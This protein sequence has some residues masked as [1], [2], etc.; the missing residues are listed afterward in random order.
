MRRFLSRALALILCLSLCL[1]PAVQALTADQLKELLREHYLNDIP[2]AALDAQTVEEVIEALNDPYTVYMDA[3]EYQAM[4]DSMSDQQVVGIGISATATEEGLLIMGTYDGSPAQK[5]GLVAGDLI[6]QVAGHNTAGETAATIT[7]WLQGEEGSKVDILVRHADG[8]EQSYTIPRAPV[9]I[10]ATVTE[11]LEDSSTGYINCTTFG[12]E[13]LGHFTEGTQA[14]DDVNL[15]IVDLRQN[16]G[17][18]VYAVTQTLGT[19]LGEGTMFY[20]RDG[21]GKYYYYAS[22][23]EST[24]IY[25]AIVLTSPMTASAAEIFA[26]A[27]KDQAGGLVIGAHTF[28]KGVAQL[29]LS[30]AQ[31]P[32]TF[33]QGDALK[34]T[35]YQYYGSEGNTAQNI[36]VVPDLLVA[37]EDADEIAQL[38]SSQS[39]AGDTNGWLRLHLGGWRWYVEIAK[40]MTADNAPYF[41]ELLSALPPSAELYLGNGADWTRTT[42]AQVAANTGVAGYAP[43][44]FADVAG[45]DCE[46]AANTLHTYAMLNGYADGSFRPDGTITRAEFCAL[47]CQAMG[48]RLPAQAYHFTDVAED[49]WYNVYI[50]GAVGAGYMNGVGEGRFDPQGLVTHEQMI[51]VLGR[52][53]AE[54][55]MTLRSASQAVPAQTGVP[56]EYSS[57]SQP[58]AWL[59]AKSQ[60]NV[61]GR[62]LNLLYND[63]EYIA[64]QAPSTRGE[65]AQVLYNIYY[66]VSVINY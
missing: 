1:A 11:K 38:F 54:L 46:R 8:R 17:G 56:G 33:D 18:D 20:L 29:I 51:T 60:K 44:V 21:E 14:Y 62:P 2:Q 26:L 15:W 6:L 3:E 57:W 31:L 27:V 16:G 34:L 39:P 49:A 40:A 19:F 53:S 66:A 5:A 7:A 10:P 63:L 23:Q 64:P 58:W 37:A 32:E 25:P 22:S 55:N 4:L 24:T 9:K 61:F 30:E 35:A 42:A 59:L 12:S 65:T 45:R 47:L 28:G 36:G 13:T 50:Q 41:A 48:L 52:M 43:R